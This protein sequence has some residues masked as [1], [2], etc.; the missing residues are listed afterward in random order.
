MTNEEAKDQ[1]FTHSGI[2]FGFIPV[3]LAF[4]GGD[5][6]EAMGKTKFY[7]VLL[8]IFTGVDTALN[9]GYSFQ[10]WTDYERL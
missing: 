6:F 10:V 9:L 2:M 8:N 5:E 1:G 4:F 3:Y 7:D